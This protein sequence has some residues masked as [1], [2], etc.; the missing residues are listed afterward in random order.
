[1]TNE[2]NRINTFLGSSINLNTENQDI[3]ELESSVFN[4]MRVVSQ[5]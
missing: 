2:T 1:M 5:D 3:R 4:S